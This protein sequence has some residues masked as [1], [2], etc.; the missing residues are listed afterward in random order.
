MQNECVV[1]VISKKRGRQSTNLSLKWHLRLGHVG[2]QKIHKMEKD[3]LIDLLG[4]DPYPTCES[5][6]KGKMA[7]SPFTGTFERATEV[8]GLVHTDICGP[9][10]EMARGGFY[11]FI[12]FTNDHSR[13]GLVYLMKQKSESFERFKEFKAL[14]ENQT[15]Q[16]IK[17]LRSDSG[18]EY[19]SVEFDEF[20]RQQEKCYN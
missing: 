11:Y 3:G 7:R 13:F 1:N 16:N 4:S 19:M 9:F 6:L 15:G 14:V 17:T 20:L 8:L 2:E 5:C 12:T 18:G 10:G